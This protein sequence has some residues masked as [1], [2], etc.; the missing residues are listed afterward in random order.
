MKS[1]AFRY[2]CAPDCF[3]KN[4]AIGSEG[5][6]WIFRTVKQLCQ[7]LLYNYYSISRLE[8]DLFTSRVFS[9][10]EA[11]RKLTEEFEKAREETD[12]EHGQTHPKTSLKH[13]PV[14]VKIE[15]A[16]LSVGKK[17]SYS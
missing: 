13:K 3:V 16:I 14:E 9:T 17:A 4:G 10:N 8:L 2:Y 7:R 5:E 6:T 11:L 1:V 15:V 12:N